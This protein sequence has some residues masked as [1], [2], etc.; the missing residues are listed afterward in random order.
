MGII[1]G[2]VL[3]GYLLVKAIRLKT[4][5]VFLNALILLTIRQLLWS[6]RGGF[7]EFILVPLKPVS[8]VAFIAVWMG[9][10]LLFRKEKKNGE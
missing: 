1:L 9:A 3:F 5:S 4:N 2:N 10:K 8:I 6:P 7:S